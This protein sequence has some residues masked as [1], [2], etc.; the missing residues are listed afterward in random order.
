MS[1]LD[2]SGSRGI[3]A[4]ISSEIKRTSSFI[5]TFV[6]RSGANGVVLGLSGGVDSSVVASLCVKALGARK[7]LGVL[8]FD[9]ETRGSLDFKDAQKLAKELRLKTLELPISD[10]IKVVERSLRNAGQSS[11][12]LTRANIKARTRMILLYAIANQKNLL[13]AGTG[14]RSEILVG[15]FTKF[16]DG[17]A[18]FLPIA[19]LYKTE[20]RALASTLRLPYTVVTKPSSPNLWKGQKASDELPAEYEVLDRILIDIFEKHMG[21][22]DVARELGIPRSLVRNTIELNK[23]TRHKREPVAFP[24]R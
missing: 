7:V 10:I 5:S 22:K 1:T 14:D 13:V 23:K 4:S 18:D 15:Y 2:Y 8:L 11:T 20:V 16:G 3:R 12:R 6:R 19:H 21:E 9:D 17:A 24:E